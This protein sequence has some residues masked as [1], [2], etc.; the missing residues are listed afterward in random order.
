[1]TDYKLV[2]YHPTP[3]MVEV[4]EDAHMLFGDMDMAL[5]MAILAAPEQQEEAHALDDAEAARL[6]AILLDRHRDLRP[7]NVGLM[8]WATAVLEQQAEQDPVG[9]QFFQDGK[10]W[11]GDDR[12]KNHRK[13]TE[14]AGIPTRDVYAAPPAAPD[15]SGLVAALEQIRDANR[16]PAHRATNAENHRM[17]FE[18]LSAHREQQT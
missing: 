5:R 16:A 3:E 9:W 15:V 17:A 1:M 4:A 11:H 7:V 8:G 14:D 10:W 13:N 6:Q 12:I 18:A 2:P